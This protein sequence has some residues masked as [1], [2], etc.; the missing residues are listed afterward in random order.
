MSVRVPLN[1]HSLCTEVM[2]PFLLFYGF[3][4]LATYGPSTMA[5]RVGLLP[6]ILFSAHRAA[7]G[8]DLT[9]L[10]R[11]DNPG[12]AGMVNQAF[13]LMMWFIAARSLTR[14]ISST[15]PIRR[16]SA[17]RRS[18][19]QVALDAADLTFNLRAVGWNISRG[20]KLPPH[21]RCTA[22][23]TRF[24]W[25]TFVSL[26]T[27]LLLSDLF[28]YSFQLL[29]PTTFTTPLGGSMYD[30]TVQSPFLKQLR[31]DA[32]IVLH[33]LIIYCTVQMFHDACALVAVGVFRQDA[34][35][36]PPIFDRPWLA[37]SLT[38]FW[39]YRWHQ[40]FRE[41]FILLGSKPLASLAGPAAGV[42]GAFLMSGLLHY[43][44]VWALDQVADK[45]I[46]LFF[47]AMAVG[48]IFEKIWAQK[49]GRRVEGHWGRLWT[50]SWLLAFGRF[51]VEAYCLSGLLGNEIFPWEQ[52]PAIFLYRLIDFVRL[53]PH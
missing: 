38:D 11:P 19:V 49:T 33:G 50:W 18:T 42:L 26:V 52:R 48:V 3:N 30:T 37:T 46:A 22:S 34:L 6:V 7:V 9:R 20:T 43:I 4:V 23:R 41:E 27:H 45:R 21:T 31:I 53:Y 5:Y 16:G 13:V 39:S 44:T 29:G 36:W 24:S 51:F 12:T 32:L 35:E 2:P 8:V 47:V 10:V 17:T 40:T 25:Q 1:L 15:T 14:T 28:H